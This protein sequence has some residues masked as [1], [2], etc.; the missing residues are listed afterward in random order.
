MG[1]PFQPASCHCGSDKSQRR[2]CDFHA[3]PRR[4]GHSSRLS[5]VET[6]TKAPAVR[7]FCP[8]HAGIPALKREAE[9]NCRPSARRLWIELASSEGVEDCFRR[10][11]IEVTVATSPSGRERLRAGK[12]LPHFPHPVHLFS[13]RTRSLLNFLLFN[14]T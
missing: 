1:P 10:I 14:L 12:I 7:S 9:S 4:D 6:V 2:T 5:Y 3:A 13:D 8:P 11:L